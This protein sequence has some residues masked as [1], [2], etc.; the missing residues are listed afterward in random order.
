MQKKG[1]LSVLADVVLGR[2]KRVVLELEG[3]KFTIGKTTFTFDG[4]LRV[5]TR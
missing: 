1:I 2:E 5:E 3:V 4:K